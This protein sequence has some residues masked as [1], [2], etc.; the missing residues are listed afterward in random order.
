MKIN[1][2]VIKILS[3][4][5]VVAMIIPSFSFASGKVSKEETVYVNLDEKG[6]PIEKTSSIWLHSDT[7]LGKVRDKSTLK[8]IK[9][10]KG[11]E[12]PKI[13]GDKI[14]W[15]TD[16][17]DIFY[18][19]KTNKD[20]PVDVEV[21]YYLNEKEVE[22]KDIAGKSGRV[23]IKLEVKNKDSHVVSMK[24]GKQKT[25]YTPFVTVAVMNMPLDKFKNVNINSGK[26]ISD[27]N[28]QVITY[29]SLP[30]I[31]E[32]LDLD[33]DTLDIPNFLEVEA[34]VTDFEMSPIVITTTSEIPEIDDI[35]SAEDLD[36]LIDGIEKIKEA[37]EKLSEA[38][39]KLYE[40]QIS[41]SGGIDEFVNGVGKVNTGAND[42]RDGTK[43]LKDGVDASYKGSQEISKGAGALAQGANELGKGTQKLEDG[44][45]KNRQ[46]A[47]Q[48]S[49]GLSQLDEKVKGMPEQTEKL[50]NGMKGVV[51][52][53][54]KIQKGQEDLTNG[55]GEA[56]KGLEKIKAGKEKELKVI[57]ILL[58]G[59]DSLDAG[60]KELKKVPGA[61]V[62]AEKIGEGLQKQR[63]ALEGLKDSS[64][65][66]IVG[67]EEVEKGI[68]Q[69][70][71]A[72]VQLSTGLGKVNEGQK[73]ISGGIS[74]LNAGSK[75]L[76]NATGKLNKGGK[77]LAKGAN[78][79]NAGASKANDGT[80]QLS[81]GSKELSTGAGKL[82]NGLG[83][84]DNGAGQ[85]YT[86]ADALS[87]GTG[88]LSNGGMKLK[89]GSDQLKNGAKELDEGMNK[90]HKEGIS[91][92]SKRIDESDLD[93]DTI[94]DTKDELI[95][96][97]KEYN[98][99]TGAS[100]E[101]E[102]SV[103]FVMKTEQIKGEE[104]K[105]ELD[106]ENKEEGK[107]GFINWLKNLFKK[108]K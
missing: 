50:D 1:S 14:V 6:A 66:L 61:S 26:L 52:N 36:E 67:A 5:I 58:N 105:E 108:E 100:E 63:M 27:G 37:S 16:E 103:K 90:F 15:E 46:G 62:I 45:K 20:L 74:Q 24:N 44:T 92:I 41:L 49:N 94:M 83:Q 17:K 88:E 55:L 40:G 89:D 78:D 82:T 64:N 97:S 106:I 21:K 9:N 33:K 34:D 85:L 75:E 4:A 39:G 98:S 54:A 38:T 56:I 84:L 77:D 93:I 99:F 7:S 102:S 95:N 35:S 2:K 23:K 28:N 42:L 57:E 96:L 60:V 91:E 80:K 73:Q 11:E 76:S 30:G 101:M 12:E 53:T 59:M 29:I 13:D 47:N 51:D 22:P 69:A 10:V 18:Q 79:L 8:E 25:L 81:N 107:S 68:K 87:K 31:K 48:L 19:G 86:G 70:Q 32:S 72:S 71:A 43:Q 104:E 3:L 65:Q